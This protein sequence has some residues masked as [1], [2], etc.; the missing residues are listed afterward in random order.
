MRA[1]IVPV[2]LS[3]GAGTRLWPESRPEQPKQLLPLTGA[4]TMLQLTVERVTGE[5]FAPPIVV[6]NAAHADMIEAQ[7]AGVSMEAL[8][9]EPVSRNT[10]PA[11]ALAAIAAGGGD[12]PLLV[13]PSDHMIGNV[14][15][16]HRAVEAALPLVEQGWLCTFGVEPGSPETGYGWIALGERLCEGGHRAAEF[17]EKPAEVRARTMLEGGR[18]YWNAGIFLFRADAFLHELTAA[19]PAIAQATA[20]A[21]ASRRD[22]GT[23]VHPDRNAFARTPAQSID[24]AV[25][26][27]AEQVAVVPVR[28]A[29]S[30]IGSWDALFDISPR[31]DKG[32]ASHGNVRLLSTANCL[33][34]ADAGVRISLLGVSDLIVVASGGEVLVLPRGRSQ[35]V[36]ELAKGHDE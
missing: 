9:L 6:A 21:M 26:E 36:R 24:Y 29:W 13:M 28:M 20:A 18:H 2:I 8:V 12:A 1:R 22:E 10:A 19:A 14:P 33:A 5:R 17:V 34:R 32:N 27:K 4:Q 30:D 3:G 16:F 7:L 23:R 25:M 15:A 11:I 31:D 35:E